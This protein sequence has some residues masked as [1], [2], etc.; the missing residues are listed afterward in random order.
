VLAN[1]LAGLA[2]TAQGELP[3]GLAFDDLML[4]RWLV[5]WGDAIVT[6]M[7]VSIFVAF[8]PQWLATYSDPLYL[9]PRPGAPH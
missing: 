1:A 8:R 9:P 4:A 7:L 3:A 2:Q 5:A 6:G